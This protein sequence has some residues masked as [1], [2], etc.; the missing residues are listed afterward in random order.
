MTTDSPVL[1]RLFPP[2]YGDDEE[3]NAGY[4][5]LA[6]PEL[7]DSRLASLAVVEDTAR[8]TTLT[9]DEITSWMRSINDVRLVLGTILEVTEDG[10]RSDP[11]E[12][13][14]ATWAAYEMLGWVLELI[15]EA[16]DDGATSSFGGPSGD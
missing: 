9:E 8:A 14:A 1:A 3:R 4:A 12:D 10:V 5:A 15:V 6:G 13:T 2:P 16:M 11:T 7:I